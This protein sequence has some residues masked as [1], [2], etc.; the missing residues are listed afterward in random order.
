[1]SASSTIGVLISTAVTSTLGT[2]ISLT[3]VLSCRTTACIILTSRS[4]KGSPSSSKYESISEG[5]MLSNFCDLENTFINPVK[6]LD[7]IS[8][9]TDIE[10]TQTNGL[11]KFDP[12]LPI[13]LD[14]KGVR[15][16]AID[17]NKTIT[18][19]SIDE[20]EIVAK[21]IGTYLIDTYNTVNEILN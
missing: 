9:S 4:S 20:L 8:I 11:I 16:I 3:T 1:M 12:S 15:F 21:E 10:A 6:L 7:N 17:L 14:V 2:I 18:M 19:N 13:M 5:V